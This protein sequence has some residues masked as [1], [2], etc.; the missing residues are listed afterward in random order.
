[1][2]HPWERWLL[3]RPNCKAV[4]PRDRIT[5]EILQRFAIPAF[6]LGNPMMDGLEWQGESSNLKA[7]PTAV[8][9]ITLLPGSR[10]PE[11]YANWEI[12]LL[13]INHLLAELPRPL[14][15]LAAI[16]PTVDSEILRQMLRQFRWQQAGE[17]SYTI[18]VGER[19]TTL[20][21]MPPRCFNECIHRADLAIAMAGTATEQFVGLG[22][23]AVIIPGAGP[24]FTAKFAEAQTRLLGAS[25]TLVETPSQTATAIQALLQDPDRL[26]WI[27]ENGLRRMGLPG[28]AQR[29]AACLLEQFS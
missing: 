16:A 22:K 29:I 23:P 9:T 11:A 18:G 26:H 3:L 28:A 4:F 21:L 15:F 19:K 20:T 6:D 24:Q 8:L 10:P 12:I 14:I 13:A 5:A 7:N 25:V 2:Y 27:V 17:A 1:V